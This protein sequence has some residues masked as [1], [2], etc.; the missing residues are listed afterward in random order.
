MAYIGD[1]TL[2]YSR[3][4]MRLLY[5]RGVLGGKYLMEDRVIQFGTRQE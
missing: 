5:F 2:M 4:L 1:Y 3:N